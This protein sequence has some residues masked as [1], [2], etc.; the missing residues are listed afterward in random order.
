MRE[1]LRRGA[2]ALLLLLY[3]PGCTYWRPVTT[4][5]IELTSAPQPPPL[6]RITTVADERLEV[7]EPRVHRDTLIGG[8]RPDTGWVY[9]PLSHIAKV[10]IRRRQPARTAAYVVLA[11]G[12]LYL[13][14]VLCENPDN[15]SSE[16]E[17]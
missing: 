1:P 12:L 4:P 3:L 11:I 9:L 7:E 5:L 10:E 17:E 13:I 6:V 8:S 2:A 14:A 16:E 15:C